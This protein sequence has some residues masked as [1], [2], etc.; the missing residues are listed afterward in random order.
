MDIPGPFPAEIFLNYSRFTNRLVYSKNRS[1]TF[2]LTMIAL[3]AAEASFEFGLPIWEYGAAVLI[4]REAGGA[5][6]VSSEEAFNVM[7]ANVIC[8]RNT[9][10]A[11]TLIKKIN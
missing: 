8:A 1:S 7:S 4:V 2:N 9:Q 6:V 5:A 11:E 10:T 3:G